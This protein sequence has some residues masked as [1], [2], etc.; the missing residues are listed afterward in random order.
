MQKKSRA[1]SNVTGLD[2]TAVHSAPASAGSNASTSA[3]ESAHGRDQVV[4]SEF[5]YE[6][7][8]ALTAALHQLTNDPLSQYGGRI[9]EHRGS[10][11][12]RLMIIGE[13]P[14]EQENEQGIPFVGEAGQLL[15]K[16]FEYGGFDMHSQVYITNVVKRR[17]PQNRAP[18]AAESAYYIP[19][20][21][22]E[23][24]LVNPEVIVLAGNVAARAFLGNHVRITKVRGNWFGGEDGKPWLMPVFHPAHLLRKESSKYEMVLDIE[25]I[26]GKYLQVVP[27]DK[28]A[29]LIKKTMS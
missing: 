11:S 17:P 8:A 18:T 9:V 24:R 5:R 1:S 21:M 16:I 15:D 23:V 25:A 28:L 4:S 13:G 2:A 29:P 6:D 10:P 14:G 12:A 22:E 3:S 19:Y 27:E 20:L 26:R 7:H